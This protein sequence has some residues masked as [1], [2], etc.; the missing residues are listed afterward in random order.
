MARKTKGQ[1]VKDPLTG[2]FIQGVSGNPSGRPLGSKNKVTVLKLAAEG[3][4]RDRNQAR[5]DAVLDQ[6]LTAALEGDQQARKLVWDAC[7]SKAHVSEDKAAGGT[8]A[9]TVHRMVVNQNKKEED[10]E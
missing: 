8:Q 7:I 2:Q 10:D 9:I 1:L 6:V 3:A 4:F 5:I